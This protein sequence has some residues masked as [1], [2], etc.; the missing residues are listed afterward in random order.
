[1]TASSVQQ[2]GDGGAVG[3]VAP[4]TDVQGAGGIRRH[5]LHLYRTIITTLGATECIA[6]R[7][8][9]VHQRPAGSLGDGE[10]DKS[11]AGDFDAG[12]G[13][14]ILQARYDEFRDGAGTLARFPGKT[15][16]HGTR[17][18]AMG[19]I[20]AALDGDLGQGAQR[21]LATVHQAFEGLLQK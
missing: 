9:L 21:Q 12:D 1:L 20:T 7:K 11:G 8:Y 2:I 16:R 10:I 17:V 5:E 6:G 3:R 19:A 14:R 15:H 13:R 4:V 18:V